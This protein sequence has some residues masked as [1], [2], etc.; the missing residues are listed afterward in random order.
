MEVGQIL[1][2]L[3]SDI[4]S[5]A[6]DV[7]QGHLATREAL[8]PTVDCI[9]GLSLIVVAICKHHARRILMLLHTI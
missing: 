6:I 7:D 9:L 2:L 5:H 4:S 1:L 3:C 8:A